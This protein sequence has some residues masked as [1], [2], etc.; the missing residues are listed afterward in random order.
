MP[1]FPMDHFH[2]KNIGHLTNKPTFLYIKT[3]GG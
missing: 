2:Y 1:Y 3:H